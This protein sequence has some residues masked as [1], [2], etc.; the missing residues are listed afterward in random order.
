MSLTFRFNAVS[1]KK[2]PLVGGRGA[3]SG[4][5][6]EPAVPQAP[7]C[8]AEGSA[9]PVGV[10]ST[11]HYFESQTILLK[12]MGPFLRNTVTQVLQSV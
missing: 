7:A 3:L 10:N 2:Q 1:I 5:W 6:P 12:Q 9:H 4:P 11:P 8:Q